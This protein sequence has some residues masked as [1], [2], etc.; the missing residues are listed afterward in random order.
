MKRDELRD[1]ATDQQ[2]SRPE[3]AAASDSLYDT[4][5]KTYESSAEVYERRWQQ[6]KNHASHNWWTAV[7]VYT[8]LASV[9]FVIL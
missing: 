2:A 6:K 3:D 9:A 4:E 1:S 7:A 8:L 5:L